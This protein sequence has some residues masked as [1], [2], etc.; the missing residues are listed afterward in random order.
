MFGHMSHAGIDPGSC[1]GGDRTHVG[2]QGA[3]KYH[4]GQGG[5]AGRGHVF[6]SGHGTK[7]KHWHPV[8]QKVARCAPVTERVLA[9]T[10]LALA[11]VTEE[12]PI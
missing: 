12:R 5:R 9:V 4:A 6:G 2:W 1:G 8:A 7:N 11:G 3:C 10:V